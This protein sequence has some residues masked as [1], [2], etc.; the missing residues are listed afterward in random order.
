MSSSVV[1]PETYGPLCALMDLKAGRQGK[2]IFVFAG[3]GSQWRA[4]GR[5][6]LQE[7]VFAEVIQV[8]DGFI[9]KELGWS[10]LEEMKRPAEQSR[11]LDSVIAQPAIFS[12]QAGL[13]TLLR[14]WGVT[15]NGVIGHSVGEVAAAW[16]AGILEL[17][18]AIGVICRQ[19]LVMQ[20]I[21]GKGHMLFAA[22]SREEME[23]V[24]V[25]CR[26]QVHVAAWNSPKSTV[27]SSQD[28]LTGIADLMAQKEIFHRILPIDIA[29]HSP[30]IDPHV[31][32]L[33]DS[34][35]DLKCH[36]PQ[37][38]IYST[39]H[40]ELAVEDDYNGSYWGAHM[41]QPVRFV[42]AMEAARADDYEYWVE[43]GPHPVMG[44]AIRECLEVQEGMTGTV[45][46]TLRRDQSEKWDLLFLLSA[47]H[48]LGFPITQESLNPIDSERLEALS[49][50]WQT[51]SETVTF[52]HEMSTKEKEGHLTS[53]LEECIGK[54]LGQEKQWEPSTGF[55]EAGFD[56][57]MALRLASLLSRRLGTPLM[58]TLIFDYPNGAAL[59]AY[60]KRR[61]FKTTE[62][63]IPTEQ[64]VPDQE[65]IAVIGMACR[66]PGR[67]H[68][69]ETFW[70]LLINARDA[71]TKIP[72]DR[73]DAEEYFDPNPDAPG[74][75]YVDCGGFLD[76]VDVKGLDQAFFHI[77]PKEADA[78][79]PQQRLLLE[80]A[81]EAVENSGINPETLR[82]C[83]V[84]VFLGISTDDYKQK[85]LFSHDLDQINA[86]SALGSMFSSAGGRLSYFM[87]LRGANVS[88]DTACSSSLAAMHLACGNLRN[89]ES[90]MALVAGVNLMTTP[91]LFIY[92]S[93][94]KAL[95]PSG[96]C[97]SF[98]ESA[99]GYARG[100]GCAV[101]VLKP[102]NSAVRDKDPILALVRG[103][104]L[105][106]DGASSGFTAPNGPAQQEVVRAA[107]RDAKLTP[108]DVQYV[109]AHGTGTPL[110]DPIEVGALGEVF[111]L[112]RKKPLLIGS[113]KANIGHLEA[114]SGLASVV[115]V[116]LSMNKKMLPPQPNFTKASTR[117]PWASLP[118]RVVTSPTAWPDE[119]GP[120]IAG[121]SSFGFSGS[122][123]HVVLEEAPAQK[124]RTA[125][126]AAC[127]LLPLS[128][129]NEEALRELAHS[130]LQLLEKEPS[131]DLFTLA[132]AAQQR[133]TAFTK[134]LAVTGKDKKEISRKL[135]AYID[136][137]T[138]L[139]MEH[140]KT[141]VAFVFTGQGSQYTGMG[142]ELYEQN[143]VFRNAMD[144]C[145]AIL[146]PLDVPLLEVINGPDDGP[147]NQT[148]YTQPCLLALGYALTR[149]WQS[150]GVSP[151]LVMGHSVGEYTAA[152]ISGLMSLEDGLKMISARARLMGE[153]PE[154]GG[155]VAV[156]ANEE[157]VSKLIAGIPD[158]TFAAVNSPMNLV[159]SG[160]DEAL[161]S[162]CLILKENGIGSQRLNVSH[163]FHSPLME[164]MKTAFE[165]V[166]GDIEFATPEVP[167]ISAL[168]GESIT[169]ETIASPKWWV[170]HM[171]DP[172]RFMDAVKTASAQGVGL[173]MEMG[174]NPVLTSFGKRMGEMTRP[175]TWLYSL[176]KG[177]GD[178][179][180]L[181]ENLGLYWATGR[182]V[183]W[184]GF[185]GSEHAPFAALPNYPFQRKKFWMKS[186]AP[187]SK[188][189]PGHP[190][191]GKALRSP[192]FAGTRVFE[193]RFD[194]NS[195]RFLHEHIIFDEMVSPGAGHVAM[196]LAMAAEVSDTSTL[197]NLDFLAPLVVTEKNPRT[198]QCLWQDTGEC[199]VV[200][201]ADEGEWLT[202]CQGLMKT[203][204]SVTQ[205]EPIR[206]NN[207]KETLS[208]KDFYQS[209]VGAG[210][211]IGP[212]YQN[213]VTIHKAHM[214]ARCLI[215]V[216]QQDPMGQDYHPGFLDSVFQSLATATTG[217]FTDLLDDDTLIIPFGLKTL[218]CYGPPR[219]ARME[220]HA[221]LHKVSRETLE[222]DIALYDEN[223]NILLLIEGL[224]LRRVERASVRQALVSNNDL[225][226]IRW[227]PLPDFQPGPQK[228][229]WLL[230]ADRSG[231]AK[232]LA[233][234]LHQK[235]IAS[236][237]IQPEEDID[238]HHYREIFT[239]TGAPSHVIYMP[240]LDVENDQE[241]DPEKIMDDCTGLLRVI[242]AM[243]SYE[244]G[245]YP[246]LHVITMGTVGAPSDQ[247]GCLR[248][249]SLWGMGK[250][251]GHEHGELWGGLIDLEPSRSQPWEEVIKALLSNSSEDQLAYRKG[252]WLAPRLTPVEKE[253]LPTLK[254]NPHGAY[255]VTGGLGALGMPLAAW[256][257]E[258]GARHLFLAGRN[259]PG[260]E[261][262][263]E[264]HRLCAMGA[265]V[266]AVQAD[267]VQEADVAHLLAQIK[268]PLKGIIHAAGILEDGLLTEATPETFRKV[269]APKA[270]GAWNLHKLTLSQD[271]DFFIM[272][273]SMAS[274]VGNRGQGNYAAANHFL[275][276]LAMYR[277]GMGLK[278]LSINW[279]P[280]DDAGM[281]H[282][283]ETTRRWLTRQG[284]SFMK[285]EESFQCLARCMASDAAQL[286]A[287]RCD[288]ASYKNAARGS[289]V[290]SLLEDLTP[291]PR[292]S[293][294][295]NREN[296]FVKQLGE[297]PL[298]QRASLLLKFILE[299]CQ[300]VLGD[301]MVLDPDQ[302]LMEQ[303]ADSLMMVEI[304]GEIADKLGT[305]LSTSDL[306][307]YP[308]IRSLC[309][310]LLR[311]KLNLGDEPKLSP[312]PQNMEPTDPEPHDIDELSAEELAALIENDLDQI[313]R[314]ISN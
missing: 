276:S 157:N 172:V 179:Q 203:T 262:Q 148:R 309:N 143:P 302:P 56:S 156:R 306:F 207:T 186:P 230:F 131:R 99:D 95:S 231:H 292:R 34:L 151:D 109:E 94:L 2:S 140:L 14:S 285:A 17:E 141:K 271:L 5:E 11:L 273:S 127:A 162:A 92:F 216:P 132:A 281:A 118:L 41:R 210:Y 196:L 104:A 122:N 242:R 254:F 21:A 163:A 290:P 167:M 126:K 46:G 226:K 312:P 187:M 267:V 71:V 241:F 246:K 42:Q 16:T 264:I 70:E 225:Y 245:S 164:P 219:G 227:K 218:S 111:G 233:E 204:T 125:E 49:Q 47:W 128:A 79:D 26:E 32:P 4:M 265:Q 101:L 275:D 295:E 301:E 268:Q 184:K 304:R 217:P 311:E 85:H 138:K 253:S 135:Q 314:E 259:L 90:E 212:C 52:S 201:C 110:G 120:R 12:L 58:P 280:W 48:H 256:M 198:V 72:E 45:L 22:V 19:N 97:H 263:A 77:P 144:A 180:A 296:P 33:A 133:R 89:K 182:S 84:S 279:G 181:S 251:A 13:V 23:E 112:K 54:V 237:I 206:V 20:K 213:I 235:R 269:M 29:F 298:I 153:L 255:L 50:L 252:L 80:V 24:L 119:D 178:L 91:N 161:E 192:A 78:L 272:F 170:R 18:D 121:V 150:W 308:D 68:T 60:L 87:G 53:L 160:R 177:Y 313:S 69:P 173:F 174:P 282:Q 123:A 310:Y 297:T 303:G 57:Q 102:L 222:G 293:T 197:H 249:S 191:I 171:L 139:E 1:V 185:A 221:V 299:Q 286:I 65:P 232:N 27:I 30:Q 103:T 9:Q 136:G 260:P 86:Y 88:V 62:E 7:P 194:A 38:P 82:N 199:R 247:I 105:N 134:R 305:M 223:G 258:Q 284:F 189:A 307:N 107:L 130:W 239:A 224:L 137:K 214:A 76:G 28:S 209:F 25:D 61:L 195:P 288:W 147:L 44:Q 152:V 98:Q 158:V 74:K 270:S 81:W 234:A 202:H 8:C 108:G 93:K 83:P 291:K 283:Q 266:K 37:I 175:A 240:A 116:I 149:L 155:M 193:T 188:A 300:R 59:N 244:A 145:A 168:T 250:V 176:R 15:P 40:G 96:H 289:K 183:S 31:Q 228:G 154:G 64:E 75:M 238:E 277:Q 63:T 248:G 205:G 66:F 243:T 43:I 39:M 220:A 113:V 6:L 159:I 124:M 200:S 294:I 236:I 215:D 169:R 10:L 100:E 114:S 274:V 129:R 165:Q 117:I 190:L 35:K 287:V 3:Q 257:V 115:K 73:W 278:G 67:A 106:Q 146:K 261:K 51:P 55:M 211:G 229:A 166:I 142:R 208:G 36:P